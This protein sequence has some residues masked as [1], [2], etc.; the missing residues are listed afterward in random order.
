[1]EGL[2]QIQAVVQGSA[3]VVGLVS[4][5]TQGRVSYDELSGAKPPARYTI[6]W[7]SIEEHQ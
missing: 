2:V 4:L 1:M 3:R 7:A 6:K 5:D